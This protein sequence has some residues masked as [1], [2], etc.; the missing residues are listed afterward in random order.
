MIE[1]R[2]KATISFWRSKTMT[3][4]GRAQFRSGSCL[5]HIKLLLGLMRLKQNQARHISIFEL[6]KVSERSLTQNILSN[7]P[8]FISFHHFH[9]LEDF[10]AAAK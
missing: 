4:K 2:S 7:L 9:I 1:L 5:A 3:K 6:I 10:F 8:L